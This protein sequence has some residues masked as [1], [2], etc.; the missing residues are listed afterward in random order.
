MFGF[1]ALYSLQNEDPTNSTGNAA[2]QDQTV[3]L[4]WTRDNIA[5]F[6]GDP[7]RVHVFGESAGGFSV[8]WHLVSQASAGLFQS[9]TMESGSFDT[10]QFF[11]PLHDAVA[12][13]ELFASTCGC[14]VTSVPSMGT[15]DP[16]LVCLRARPTEAL[17][18]DLIDVFNPNWPNP[19]LV[20]QDS[21]A[22]SDVYRT[23]GIFA[24]ISPPNMLPRKYPSCTLYIAL[25]DS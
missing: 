8:A 23:Q 16:L 3:A 21:H 20:A 14:N 25:C 2:L 18:K 4:Q 11:T 10:T 6:G 22:M 1:A 9:A 24:D 12:F 7:N 15:K 13:T 5:S 19:P 17:M